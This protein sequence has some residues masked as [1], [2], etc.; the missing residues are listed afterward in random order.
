MLTLFLTL[1]S[2]AANAAVTG[3]VFS[4]DVKSGDNLVSIGARFGAG[5][6]AL[7]RAN[8]VGEKA[9][10]K[11]GQ[12]LTVDNSHIVPEP[13]EEGALINVPQRMLYLFH[14]NNVIASYPVGL[15][16]PSW[17]TPT[18]EFRILNLEKNKCWCVPQ[19][20]QEEMRRE[21]KKV[22][23][24]VPPG[25]DNP[26]GGYWIGLNMPGF[27]I[28]GTIAPS[29]IYRFQSHGCIRMHPEDIAQL[30]PRV[31]KGMRGRLIY[32]PVMIEKLAGGRV[33]AEVHPDIYNRYG[34]PL[35]ALRAI[36]GSKN[37]TA[38]ID[39]DK[40]AEVAAERQGTPLD[41]GFGASTRDSYAGR[42]E[43]KIFVLDGSRRNDLGDAA[44]RH[45]GD[46]K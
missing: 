44:N 46:S 4:Y 37:L 9:I 7:A 18:G 2:I 11:P 39:W 3:G 45:R 8:S 20:I 43:A 21:G 34:S 41:I 32:A 1:H 38:E 12:K 24:R 42:D 30:F 22:V 33:L 26:L 10:I 19:S 17:P 29:S 13:L 31:Q 15:G 40:A 36:A 35:S 25:P 14:E 28:H 23:T 16:K 5:A 27:G 6:R